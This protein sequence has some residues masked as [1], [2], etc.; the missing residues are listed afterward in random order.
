MEHILQFLSV[1]INNKYFLKNM[2]VKMG[3]RIK[4]GMNY[5]ALTGL[6]IVIW[7]ILEKIEFINPITLPAPET[8]FFTAVSM[9][10]DGS[11][12]KQIITSIIRVLEGY[13][14]ASVLGIILGLMLGLSDRLRT[15]CDL[16]IQ[17]LR[18]IPALGWIPL[19]VLWFGIDEL[20][21][22][23]I[24]F[25]GGFFVVLISVMDGIRQVDYKLIEVANVLEVPR[26]RMIMTLII[27][28]ALPS[29]FTGMRVALASCWTCVVAAELVASSSGIGYMLMNARQFSMSDV[30]MVGM[31]S[32]GITGKIMDFLLRKMENR[33]T[34]YE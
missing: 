28:A 10:R 12:E 20:S 29:I 33:I 8:I 22:V 25:L 2:G 24:I 4:T 31:F 1:K 21:K 15:R 16:I 17:I 30:V 27:P 7:S 11:L 34:K 26:F 3:I 9:L 13:A 5:F 19:A 6:L 14:L 23:F 18:P 32:I